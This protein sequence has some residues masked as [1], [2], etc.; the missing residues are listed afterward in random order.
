MKPYGLLICI[1]L[2]FTASA[3]HTKMEKNDAS[4]LPWINGTVVY[5]DTEGGFYGIIGSQGGRFDPV[6]LP[7]RFKQDGL[8]I[9][10]KMKKLPDRMSYHMWAPLVEILAIEE[11]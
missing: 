11:V 3:C 4:S 6:N 1:G 2:V 10:F 7:D 5:V 9:R 8:P